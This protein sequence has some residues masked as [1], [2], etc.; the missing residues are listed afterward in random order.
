MTTLEKLYRSTPQQ[1]SPTSLDRQILLLAEQHAERRKQGWRRMANWVPMATSAIVASLALVL[2]LK[3]GLDQ[4]STPYSPP[5]ADI[6]ADSLADE[7]SHAA[8]VAEPITAEPVNAELTDEQQP[9]VSSLQDNAA[10]SESAARNAL[11]QRSA[12]QLEDRISELASTPELELTPSGLTTHS[13]DAVA[14]TTNR[15]TGQ[16]NPAAKV[17]ESAIDSSAA[18]P[19]ADENANS[20]GWL[21]RQPPN[22]YTI[23]LAVSRDLQRLKL[24]IARASLD[25][26]K[27]HFIK[28][29]LRE[30]TG[31]AALYGS[32]NSISQAHNAA[33]K[34]KQFEPWVRQFSELQ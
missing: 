18:V 33:N 34:I 21:S 28:T 22:A 19:L 17:A 10:A 32:W 20:R 15:F 31:Y 29:P 27:I 4:S 7:R 12:R 5:S 26:A 11:I 6:A 2:V 8:P 14:V 30:D 16:T 25:N 1:Q 3:P 24:E 13:N 23:Q 9:N